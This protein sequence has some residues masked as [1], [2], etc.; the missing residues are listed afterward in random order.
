MFEDT[1]GANSYPMG[2]ADTHD[3]TL[4][5]LEESSSGVNYGD[6]LEAAFDFKNRSM[7]FIDD[8]D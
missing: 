2:S 7:I 8:R 4:D 6:I 1:I 3:E 5:N